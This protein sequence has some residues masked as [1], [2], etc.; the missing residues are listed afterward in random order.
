MHSSRRSIPLALLLLFLIALPA[1]ARYDVWADSNGVSVRQGLHVRWDGAV[2]SGENGW[3]V[4][5]S[6]ARNGGLDVYSQFYD[7]NGS[8]VGEAG[9]IPVA[10][11]PYGQLD[12]VVVPSQDGGWYLAMNDQREDPEGLGLLVPYLQKLTAEGQSAWAGGPILIDAVPNTYERPVLIPTSEGNLITAHSNGFEATFFKH[13]SNGNPLWAQNGY[14]YYTGL[15]PLQAVADQSGGIF[16][17]GR[18]YTDNVSSLVMLHIN[19]DGQL[20]EDEVLLFSG[21]DEWNQMVELVANPAGGAVAIWNRTANFPESVATL[22]GCVVD[23]DFNA[24][25][26]GGEDGLLRGGLEI[27]S[28]A[29]ATFQGDLILAAYIRATPLTYE[30]RGQRIHFAEEAAQLLWDDSETGSGTLMATDGHSDNPRIQ[31]AVTEDRIA[32]TTILNS[33]SSEVDFRTILADGNAVPQWADPA[34]F[35]E[36]GDVSLVRTIATGEDVTIVLGTEEPA[37]RMLKQVRMD[38][39]S[40][41]ISNPLDEQTVFGGLARNT[42]SRRV[43]RSGDNIYAGW[44]DQR[45]GVEGEFPFLQRL[46]LETGQ[47]IWAEDGINLGEFWLDPDSVEDSYTAFWPLEMTPDGQGGVVVGWLEFDS[48]SGMRGARFQRIDSD[49]NLLWGETGRSLL[50]DETSYDISTHPMWL[51]SQADGTTAVAF[52]AVDV[53]GGSYTERAL[54]QIFGPDGT[55]TAD[56]GGPIELYPLADWDRTVVGAVD[57][58]DGSLFFLV[59]GLSLMDSDLYACRYDWEGQPHYESFAVI[60]Q[61]SDFLRS[62]DLNRIGEDVLVSWINASDEVYGVQWN[63][64]TPNGELVYGEEGAV[65]LEGNNAIFGYDLATADDGF[66]LAWSSSEETRY[67]KYTFDGEPQFEPE[68]GRLIPVVENYFFIP[69]LIP[70]LGGG[71]Y[72]LGTSGTCCNELDFSYTHI[73]PEGNP[74]SDLYAEQG[75]LPLVNTWYAQRE[76]FA[77]PD[78]EGGFLATW[79]DNRS[80]I[81]EDVYAMRVNDYLVADLPEDRSNVQPDQFVLEPAYPNPFNPSTTVRF[82]IPEAGM[83]RLSVYDILGR[84]VATLLD[85]RMES[86]SHALSWNGR[87]FTGQPVAS[88]TYILALDNQG[89]SR[90]RRIVLLK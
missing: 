5:W 14:T 38:H 6:D 54:L 67:Q 37:N 51:F 3:L 26:I 49:G 35:T 65:L 16:L 22:E 60:P 53:Y 73:D 28:M 77:V 90:A 7:T 83:V 39:Q 66:W 25:F 31:L 79:S 85:R 63:R 12:A 82:T 4:A 44:I 81:A 2:A 52:T 62:F 46:D 75:I 43:I 72:I 76:L 58:N 27:K 59:Q 88:G 24:E 23:E 20:A 30:V 71:V 9:G 18:R 56:E 29:A 34:L 74:A 89:M 33:S 19:S 36:T 21:W 42:S 69:E 86:G 8:P 84:Q 11:G 45:Y 15:Y 10:S 13:D 40:S 47:P 50:P 70:D 17:L 80:A 57:A 48:G 87:D 32:F 64:I 61:M 41:E 55:R 68:L 78:G 1:Q